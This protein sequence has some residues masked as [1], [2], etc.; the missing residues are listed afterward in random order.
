MH[1]TLIALALATTLLAGCGSGS[2]SSLNSAPSTSASQPAGA[3]ATLASAY[4][5]TVWQD[6]FANDP[7]GTPSS[8]YWAAETGN[9]AEYGNRGWGNNEAEYYLPSNATVSGGYLDL[10]GHA[11]PSVLNDACGVSS[12]NCLFSSAKLTSVQTVDLSKPGFLEI[13]ASL[14][15]STGSWPALWL[16]PGTSPGST[17]PPSTAQLATQPTW[18][19]GGEIDIAEWFGTYFSGQNSTVQSTLHLPSGTPNP[20]YTDS[21]EYQQT[22]LSSPIA[23]NFHLYQLAW[24]PGQIQFA[25]DDQV[26]MTCTQ[27]TMRCTPTVAGLAPYPA[28]SLWPYGTTYKSYYLIMNLAIGG[29]LGAP[30]Q[31]NT[32]V[33]A[34]YDQTMNVAYVR[35]MTP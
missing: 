6:N 19:I 7:T 32:Q 27:S 13:K 20:N 2:I 33:P 35:Y 10:H 15:T 4:K 25:V 17:F 23:G 26:V 16:L 14:P 22:T 8:A 31:D 11:D 1:K 9:G 3:A 21:Y 30:H 12:G 29:N 28:S 5:T 34:N 24:T 18:P